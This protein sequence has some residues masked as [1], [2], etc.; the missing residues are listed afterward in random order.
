LVKIGSVEYPTRARIIDVTG[1]DFHGL[2][3]QTPPGSMP[4]VGEEGLAEYVADPEYGGE[5]VRITLDGGGV[6]WG[7]DCWWE[8][9]TGDAAASPPEGN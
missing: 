5:S 7:Y 4:H 6:L 8:P 9:I 1:M 3:I 2:A